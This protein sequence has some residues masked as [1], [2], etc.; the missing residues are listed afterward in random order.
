M[1]G[2]DRAILLRSIILDKDKGKGLPFLS[3]HK[4]MMIKEGLSSC[5]TEKRSA[6]SIAEVTYD[7]ALLIDTLRKIIFTTIEIHQ[8]GCSE[9]WVFVISS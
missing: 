7:Y 6:V 2:T 3:T 8:P 9:I 4:P 5:S 1:P